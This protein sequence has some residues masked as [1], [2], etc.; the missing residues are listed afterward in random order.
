MTSQ[1]IHVGNFHV[2]SEPE[3]VARDATRPAIIRTPSDHAAPYCVRASA[4][5]RA[6]AAATLNGNHIRSWQYVSPATFI[7]ALKK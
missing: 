1:V 7:G 2:R 3:H 6:L 4:R 5:R